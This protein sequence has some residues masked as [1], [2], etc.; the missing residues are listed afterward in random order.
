MT[1]IELERLASLANHPGYRALLKLLDE[2][3]ETLLAALET[4]GKEKETELLNLWRASRRFKKL[5][6]GRPEALLDE[7][8]HTFSDRVF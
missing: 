2:A 7:L 5:I 1:Q 3:D 4:A 6:D 8:G